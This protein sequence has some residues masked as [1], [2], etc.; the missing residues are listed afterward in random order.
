VLAERWGSW[1]LPHW[2][3]RQADPAS[4]SFA[5]APDVGGVTNRTNLD[6]VAVGVLDGS[7]SPPSTLAAW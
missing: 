3:E 5:P 1:V 7:T 6:R 4:P 2:L